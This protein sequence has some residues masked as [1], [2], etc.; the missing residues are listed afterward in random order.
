M[1]AAH[2]KDDDDARIPKAT[3]SAGRTRDWKHCRNCLVCKENGGPTAAEL[4]A[5]KEREEQER[6]EAEERKQEEAAKKKG[7]GKG[8]K[9]KGATKK[10]N[11]KT[12]SESKSKANKNSGNEND[13]EGETSA[14]V[15]LTEEEYGAKFMNCVYCPNSFHVKCLSDFGYYN[16]LNDIAY[17]DMRSICFHHSC[18]MCKRGTAAAGG[19]LFRCLECPRAFCEDCVEQDGIECLGRNK[20]YETEYGYRTKQ[21]YYIRCHVCL[22]EQNSEGSSDDE[23]GDGDEEGDEGE[24]LEMEDLE[25][26]DAD[27][28][29][30]ED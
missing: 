23:D 14:K 21:G 11:N 2:M 27:P 6:R 9:G 22:T 28:T 7:R 24:D 3:I 10:G 4:R 12:S 17:A 15:P 5:E 29:P 26:D 30:E 13:E 16:E 25:G 18:C 1:L 20:S 19:M 8:K